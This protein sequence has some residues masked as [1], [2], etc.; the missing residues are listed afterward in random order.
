MDEEALNLS[1]RRF[2]KTLG[3]TAQR[4]IEI[5]VREGVDSGRLAGSEE[6]PA[7]AIVT[8]EGLD[9]P[10]EVDGTIRLAGADPD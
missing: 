6:L 5:G 3:V 9:Q 10:I 7:R 4:E 1:V 2:L 8:V